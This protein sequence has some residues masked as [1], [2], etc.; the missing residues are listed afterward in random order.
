MMGVVFSEGMVRLGVF[1]AVL[2][3]MAT[4]EALLPRRHRTLPRLGRWITNMSIVGLGAVVVRILGFLASYIAFPLVAVVAAIYAGDRGWGL[5]NWLS[6]PAWLELLLALAALDFAIWFQHLASHR[7]PMLWQVHQVHHADRDIDVTTALRFH[8]V[9]IGLS[10]L[11]KVVWVIALGA[12]PAAVIAFEI[13]LNALAMFNHANVALPLWLDRVL[14]T[15][16]VTPDMHRVHHSVHAKE[17]HHNFG[18]NLSIWDRLFATYT[19]QPADG[20][21][22]MTIGLP[23]YQ[24]EAPARLGWSLGLPFGLEHNRPSEKSDESREKIKG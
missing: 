19:A 11:Y 5:F 14:R 10:M 24:T 9:E 8:P 17:H 1:L 16:I 3:L 22:G 6:W 12:S 20:H 21:N 7:V 4:A 13:G 15:F 18:F 2:I 23:E